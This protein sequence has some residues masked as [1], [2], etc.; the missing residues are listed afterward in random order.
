MPVFCRWPC[1]WGELEWLNAQWE[2]VDD[3]IAGYAA[4]SRS[5]NER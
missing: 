5:K 2:R 1:D 4:T 3:W